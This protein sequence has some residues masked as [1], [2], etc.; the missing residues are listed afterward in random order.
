MIAK[1]DFRLDAMKSHMLSTAANKIAVQQFQYDGQALAV[2]RVQ[3]DM[4]LRI[5]EQFTKNF[6][7]D[8]DYVKNG[9]AI[10]PGAVNALL[11][12]GGVTASASSVF[13]SNSLFVATA[14]PATLMAI[15]NG[16]GSAVMGATGI[17]GHAAFVSAGVAVVPLVLPL[18]AFQA[19]STAM[20]LS[21]LRTVS[22]KLDDLKL[23]LDRV[24]QRTEATCVGEL[25]S[26][27]HRLR[28]LEE[29]FARCNRFTPSMIARLAIL[30]GQVNP[31]F[32]RYHFLHGRRPDLA[33]AKSD[34][35]NYSQFDTYLVMESSLLDLRLDVLRLKLAA[36]EDIGLAVK[37]R[38]RLLGKVERYALLWDAI[39]QEPRDIETAAV[40]LKE[41]AEAMSWWRRKMPAY[42]GGKRTEHKAQLAQAENLKAASSG[43]LLGMVPKIAEAKT[44]ASGISEMLREQKTAPVSLIY[45]RDEAGEHSFYTT[46]LQIQAATAAEIADTNRRRNWLHRA[47]AFA[48]R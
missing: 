21:E 28:D 48:R 5:L 47:L 46:D 6:A 18:V 4:R 36:Q 8:G 16:V 41:A 20:L 13:F 15:G 38:D 45:W 27:D 2:L 14:N 22:A 44:A 19:M 26:A 9:G 42:V 43:G 17:A 37:A 12:A 29:D 7:A 39:A 23:S 24:I 32:E 3:G 25:I 35:L 30:E 11:A 33:K 1:R 40:E 10:S 31:I 34:D